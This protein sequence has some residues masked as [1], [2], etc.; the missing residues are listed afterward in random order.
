MVQAIFFDQDNTLVN[1]REVAE[2]AYRAGLETE[3]NWQKWREVIEKIKLST[4]PF[5]RT[6]ENSLRMALGDDKIGER[7]SKYRS[8]LKDKIQLLPGV[9]E[10]FLKEK[11]AKYYILT[12]EDFEDQIEIKL[13]KFGLMD[14]FDL[15]INSS[16]VGVM[17]PDINYFKIGWNEFELDPSQCVYIGDN[18]E[19]DC[20][21]G[22]DFA[23]FYELS[24]MI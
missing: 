21:M 17:K 4:N 22:I 19:K 2:M 9:K 10:F 1:T 6:F 7:L 14:K 16:K 12:T 3:E 24:G 15:I 8:E 20:V 23:D 13:G 11:K 18:F 5:E